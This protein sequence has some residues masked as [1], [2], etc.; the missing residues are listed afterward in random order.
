MKT[1]TSP[2]QFGIVQ[3]IKSYNCA[4]GGGGREGGADTLG[5]FLG[6]FCLVAESVLH[7]I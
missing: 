4:H 6:A 1:S 2:T 5:G 3:N 7:F